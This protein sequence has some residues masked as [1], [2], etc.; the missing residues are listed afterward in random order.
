MWGGTAG[1]KL[2]IPL[3]VARHG[4]FKDAL[5]LKGFGAPG[6]D[7]MKDVD[8]AG[9]AGTVTIDLAAVKIPPGEHIIYFQSPMKGKFR[10]KDVSTVGY[11]EP[12]R[13]SIKA[14][15]AKKP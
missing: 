4:E 1:A 5:K 13:I 10:G 2:E 6:I 8:L 11:S 9:D 15:E 7:T 12:I 3:K 14:P